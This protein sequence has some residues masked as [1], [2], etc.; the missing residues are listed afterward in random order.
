MPTLG[1]RSGYE[2]C[3]IC[4]WEDDGQDSDDA[5][6]NRGGPNGNYSLSEARSNFE[7]YFTMYRPED[8]YRFEMQQRTRRAREERYQAIEKAIKSNIDDDWQLARQVEHKC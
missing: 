1:E 6:E 4:D 3:T 2:I 8:R 5:E 7:K